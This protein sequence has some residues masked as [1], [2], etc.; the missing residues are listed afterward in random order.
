MRLSGQLVERSL[1][2]YTP[3]GL[4]VVEG[5]LAHQADVVQ[6]GAPRTVQFEFKA[7]AVGDVARQFEREALGSALELT[8]F[9]APRR[10]GSPTLV[11]NINAYTRMTG[12]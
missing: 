3:A 12:V 4:P 10:R 6:A 2:R 7:V 9:L 8:G 1:L 5:K 11:L